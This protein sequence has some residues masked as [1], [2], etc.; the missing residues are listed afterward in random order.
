MHSHI[1]SVLSSL[2]VYVCC[3]LSWMCPSTYIFHLQSLPWTHVFHRFSKHR[4]STFPTSVFHIDFVLAMSPEQVLMSQGPVLHRVLMEMSRSS[5]REW[6][7]LRLLTL[8]VATPP[9]STLG[10]Y[11]NMHCLHRGPYVKHL[12]FQI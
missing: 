11:V 3:L 2:Y 7:S 12:S 5:C 6:A 8:L 1:M 9:Q 10:T 4:F